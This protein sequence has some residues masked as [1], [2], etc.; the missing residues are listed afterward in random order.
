[1]LPIPGPLDETVLLLLALLL[2]LFYRDV[3][4]DASRRAA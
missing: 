4:A 1:M 3:L 2:W